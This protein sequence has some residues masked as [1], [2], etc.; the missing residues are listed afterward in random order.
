[1]TDA[2]TRDGF[3][4]GALLIPQPCP[5]LAEEVPKLPEAN[6]TSLL[7][8]ECGALEFVWTPPTIPVSPE[9]GD[10]GLRVGAAHERAHVSEAAVDVRL[11]GEQAMDIEG[12][13]VRIAVGRH[14]LLVEIV[15]AKRFE[16]ARRRSLVAELGIPFD[17]LLALLEGVQRVGARSLRSPVDLLPR[18][19]EGPGSVVDTVAI[20]SA[21]P[22]DHRRPRCQL[23]EQAMRRHVDPGLDDLCTDTDQPKVVR[24]PPVR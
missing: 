7:R 22:L 4:A 17:E 16:R 15:L 3:P 13:G 24:H 8:Y 10:I 23:T 14:R 20:Q 2:L 21:Q 1:R 11:S 6:G 12:P 19:E 9:D 5:L 18:P